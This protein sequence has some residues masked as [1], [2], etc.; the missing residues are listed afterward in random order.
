LKKASI[1]KKQ[2]K[3]NCI[4]AL[5]LKNKKKTEPKM[6]KKKQKKMNKKTKTHLR[7]ASRLQAPFLKDK[8]KTVSFRIF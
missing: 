3:K 8:E 1:H 2:K 6:K 5:F 4:Q 7:R